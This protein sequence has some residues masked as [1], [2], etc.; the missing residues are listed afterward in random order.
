MTEAELAQIRDDST[1]DS[2]DRLAAAQQLIEL[3]RARLPKPEITTVSEIAPFAIPKWVTRSDEEIERERAQ[4]EARAE[5]LAA[6]EAAQTR[7]KALD[8][9]RNCGVHLADDD[10]ERIV[11][12]KHQA[13]PATKAVEEWLET[14][15]PMLVLCGGIGAG[16][17][18]AAA[19]AHRRLGGLCLR[20]SRLHIA[21]A[22]W[23]G[24]AREG[25]TLVDPSRC[26]LVVLD[27]LGTE[28]DPKDPRWAEALFELVDSRMERQQ[29]T[30]I[31][32]NLPRAKFRERYDW[33][34]IDRLNH[35][36]RVV[37]LA[38]KSMRTKGGGL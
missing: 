36:A 24:E 1:R 18:F 11:D 12:G 22:P 2:A 23:R 19:V 27:D 28:R 3:A 21:L 7:Y 33:R 4:A 6:R 37:E 17:T 34:V 20:A 15:V 8:A 32:S 10:L 38:D 14:R 9:L 25:E 5:R 13:T 30:L 35:V 26:Q 31:T 29:R 16:K